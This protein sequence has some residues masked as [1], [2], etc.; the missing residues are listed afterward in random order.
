MNGV[1]YSKNSLFN[2]KNETIVAK[3]DTFGSFEQPR[4]AHPGNISIGCQTFLYSENFGHNN[5]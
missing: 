3:R 1:K 2:G 5:S 4:D